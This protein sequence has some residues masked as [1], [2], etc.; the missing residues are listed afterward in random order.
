[1]RTL[2]LLTEAQREKARGLLAAH[3]C[4]V[5]PGR[6]IMRSSWDFDVTEA[7]RRLV[8]KLFEEERYSIPDE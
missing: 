1:M 4:E 5:Y 2:Q 6:Y 3:G 8:G 7:Q